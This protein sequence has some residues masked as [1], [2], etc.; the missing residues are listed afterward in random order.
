MTAEAPKPLEPTELRTVAHR[1]F[2]DGRG[3]RFVYAQSSAAILAIDPLSDRLLDAFEGEGGVAHEILPRVEVAADETSSDN[4]AIDVQKHEALR[5]L[6]DLGLIRP[7]GEIRAPVADL[8]PMP[9]PLATLVLNVTNKCNLSCTYCYEYG[10][11]KLG[12]GTESKAR[13]MM[14]DDTARE[15]IDFLFESAGD[16]PQVAITFFGG[17]TLLNL[18]AVKAAV[19]HAEELGAKHRKRVHYSITTNATLLST[20]VIDFL[21][22]NRFGVTISIDG[23]K[24]S[25]DTHRVFKSGKGSFA[26]IE[27][28]IR[29][30]IAVN[31]ERNGRPIGARVTLTRE[32]KSVLETYRFL[33]EDM[34]FDE[35][36]FAPVTADPNRDYAL[37][38]SHYDGMLSEFRTLAEDFVQAATEGRPHGFA[39]LN[40]LLRELH[41]GVNKAHPCGAGLGLLGVST[42]GDLGLCHRFVESD[43]H[44]VGNV[45]DGLDQVAR[46]R[47]LKEGHVDKKSECSTCFARPLCAGGCY[48]EAQVRQG[49][50]SAP[51]LHA[52]EWIRGWTDIGLSS[53]ARIMT[54]NPGFFARFESA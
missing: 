12:P 10:E 43:E 8:P 52:C 50:P 53:Y 11:D 32:A 23:D 38:G 30:L 40:D 22:S 24:D 18:G 36:G 14:L 6:V 15:S 39:N 51:N 17:E 7:A 48:H 19:T 27:P 13:P 47:F 9:F 33:C 54:Q 20:E 28:P 21:T 29:K 25:Q 41:D 42:E 31:K 35:V 49:D 1:R 16:R 46:T 45:R 34:G 26:M 2:D 3:H 44:S 37:E 4:R 5:D